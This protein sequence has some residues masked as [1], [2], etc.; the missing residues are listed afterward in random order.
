MTFAG[1]RAH[2]ETCLLGPVAK[3][4]T[5]PEIPLGRDRHSALAS[6][7]LIND[8]HDLNLPQKAIM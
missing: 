5:D 4:F 2:W 3:D 1:G 7:S 6:S 8:N